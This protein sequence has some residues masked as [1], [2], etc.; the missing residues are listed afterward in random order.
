MKQK[1]PD[2]YSVAHIFTGTICPFCRNSP[3]DKRRK[4]RIFETML[5]IVR[6]SKS[7]YT[8]SCSTCRI[9]YT[10]TWKSLA[11]ALLKPI[12]KLDEI[13]AKENRGLTEEESD[14]YMINFNAL[15]TL[16]KSGV[17]TEGTHRFT[18][19]KGGDN[20]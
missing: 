1:Y 18:P 12:R 9:R 20:K 13:K 15:S 4:N 2:A 17:N 7:S 3:R 14:I 6:A 8:L 16:D 11:D 19:M 5:Q 10:I